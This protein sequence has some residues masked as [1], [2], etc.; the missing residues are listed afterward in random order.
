MNFVTVVSDSDEPA[1]RLAS[2]LL[3]AADLVVRVYAPHNADMRWTGK[4]IVQIASVA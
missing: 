4:L 3:V 2:A 1:D